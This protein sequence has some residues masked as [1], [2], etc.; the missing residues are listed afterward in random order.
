M[1]LGILLLP[2]VRLFC[3]G[4]ALS[5]ALVGADLG[6]DLDVPLLGLLPISLPNL[7]SV[8]IINVPLRFVLRG[9]HI[10]PLDQGLCLLRLLSPEALAHRRGNRIHDGLPRLV[11]QVGHSFLLFGSALGFRSQSLVFLDQRQ[12]FRLP[13]LRHNFEIRSGVLA[14]ALAH[15]PMLGRLIGLPGLVHGQHA[16]QVLSLPHLM[17]LNDL[18]PL[19]EHDL[20][21]LGKPLHLERSLRFHPL[22][23]CLVLVVLLRLPLD[24]LAPDLRVFLLPLLLSPPLVQLGIQSCTEGS[25]FRL[26]FVCLLLVASVVLRVCEPRHE[27]EVVWLFHSRR[28]WGRLPEGGPGP[29]GGAA[30]GRAHHGRR[31]RGA[32]PRQ[33]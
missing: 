21:L 5:H 19:R 9:V 14:P 3:V 23:L 4:L 28:H 7:F 16:I 6:S 22:L 10:V 15:L 20:T 26:R 11:P 31:L 8:P 13:H 12:L 24:C 18:F 2:G 27:V 1:V 29:A 17:L 25:M 33:R 32:G 30:A